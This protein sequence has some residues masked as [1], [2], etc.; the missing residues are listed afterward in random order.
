MRTIRRIMYSLVFISI[1]IYFF[2]VSTDY[3]I[4]LGVYRLFNEF[5]VGFGRVLVIRLAILLM[6]VVVWAFLCKIFDALEISFYLCNK[7]ISVA[8][9]TLFTL[10]ICVLVAGTIFFIY[11]DIKADYT[12]EAKILEMREL[13]K[14]EKTV[15]HACGS[16]SSNGI[17]Y[18]YTNSKEALENC[19]Q[20]G[21]RIVEIDFMKSKDEKLVCAHNSNHENW[22][23]GIDAYEPL[24]E[25]EFLDYKFMEKF[26]TMGITWLAEYMRDHEDLYVVTDIK[27][28]NYQACKYIADNYSDLKDR[29]IIQIFHISQYQDIRDLGFDY[30]IFT[31]YRTN[32]DECEPDVLQ[33]NVRHNDLIG[34]TF[35]ESWTKKES[36]FE[37]VRLTGVPLFVHT[38]NE[39]EDMKGDIEKGLLVYTDNTDNSWIR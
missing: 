18:S 30:I 3:E 13:V 35:W 29:F 31:L 10:M 36:F 39:I 6:L 17:D 23:H 19:Y 37:G 22:A 1:G 33:E 24:T 11:S 32:E 2:L 21:N 8:I 34:L 25:D 28:G 14:K 27:G 7:N 9:N 15:I 5:K 4:D 16:I 12:S 20:Q 38:V 26:S